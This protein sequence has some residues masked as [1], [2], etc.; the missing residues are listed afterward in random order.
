MPQ[1][2]RHK[3]L[4][5]IS[6]KQKFGVRY[7]H[8]HLF[9]DDP[10]SEED[11]AVE[12]SHHIMPRKTDGRLCFVRAISGLML[13]AGLILALVGG[14]VKRREIDYRVHKDGNEKPVGDAVQYNS[15]LDALV[16]IG[17]VLMMLGGVMLAAVQIL[18]CYP[19]M[20]SGTRKP[21][22]KDPESF[23]YPEKSESEVASKKF[24]KVPVYALVHKV[25][26]KKKN[27]NK[28]K[29][30]TNLSIKKPKFKTSIDEEENEQDN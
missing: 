28:L 9:K 13:L 12:D 29:D 14:L 26:P 21:R 2:K 3:R 7:L 1:F 15:M 25:Q 23:L 17:S 4:K 5:R 8:Q 10:T 22:I 19:R 24:D 11:S 16:L 30:R 27:G 6:S 20:K 18:I